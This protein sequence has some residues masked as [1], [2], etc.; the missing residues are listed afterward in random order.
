M[1]D[2]TKMIDPPRVISGS[3]FCT[4]KTGVA[5]VEVECPVKMIRRES[6]DGSLL[7]QGRVRHDDIDGTLFVLYCRSDT[8][9]VIEVRGVSMD[10]GDVAPDPFGDLVE[11]CLPTAEDKDV[12]AF[13]DKPLGG[14]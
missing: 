2:E 7:H 14:R 5:G 4:R 13:G 1:A 3:S 9:E 11:L 6:V 10:S 12:S 8:V